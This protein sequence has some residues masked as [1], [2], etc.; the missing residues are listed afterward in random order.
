MRSCP[1]SLLCCCL[2]SG[3][4]LL[5]CPPAPLVP[6]FSALLLCRP[7]AIGTRTTFALLTLLSTA[8]ACSRADNLNGK[9]RIGGRAVGAACARGG[10]GARACTLARNCKWP[11]AV[12]STRHPNSPLAVSCSISARRPRPR[13]LLAMPA[14][15]IACTRLQVRCEHAM[16]LMMC[17]RR[18]GLGCLPWGQPGL[19]TTRAATPACK[20][21]ARLCTR[22][23]N[24]SRPQRLQP[25]R[26]HCRLPPAGP[27]PG[28]LRDAEAMLRC[29][30]PCA[31]RYV[32]LLPTLC[33][34]TQL[35]S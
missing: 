11:I 1:G 10:G 8:S 32:S 29:S 6:T 7:T 24:C 27:A 20:D 31:L 28:P 17:K 12:H 2:H 15:A 16:L 34:P 5:Q 19:C 33:T 4:Q 23:M 21:P 14:L 26:R 18:L 3:S 13:P 25:L 22:D 30:Q 9:A 35:N